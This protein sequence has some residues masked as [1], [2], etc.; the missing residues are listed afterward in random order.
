M[1]VLH[2]GLRRSAR[3]WSNKIA[4]IDGDRRLTYAQLN[5]RVNRLA[6]ALIDLGLEPGDRVGV[7]ML[8]SFRYLEL[9][10]AVNV[11]GGVIVPLN[12]RLA[13]PELVFMLNDCSARLLVVGSEHAGATR[14]I[15]MGVPSLTELILA[16]DWGAPEPFIPYEDFLRSAAPTA[17]EVSVSDTDPA[18]IFY[19]GGTTGVPKGVILTDR[20]LAA[21]AYHVII[22]FG[23]TNQTTYLHT[24]PMFHLADAGSIFAVTAV[25]GAH[26]HSRTFDPQRVLETIERNQVTVAMF[27]PT[28]VTVLVNHPT[29]SNFD[30]SR[31]HRVVYGGSPIAESTLR[32][33]MEVLKCEFIQGYGM[34]EASPLISVLSADDHRLDGSEIV[35]QRLRSAGQPGIGI[36]VRI[37]NENDQE[38]PPETVGEIILRG[39]NVMLG[40]WNRPEETAQVLRGGWLHTGDLGYM[41]DEDYVFIVDRKKDM[42]VSGGEKVGEVAQATDSF[43]V[44]SK[45]FFFPTDRY[46]P[47]SAISN[48]DDA[49][50]FLSLTKD[51]IDARGWEDPDAV[52]NLDNND[53]GTRAT[54]VDSGVPAGRRTIAGSDYT[55]DPAVDDNDTYTRARTTD[56]DDDRDVQLH[57]ER[58][59]AERT[60]GE[61]GAV[62]VGKKVES[63]RETVDVPVDREEVD[64]EYEKYDSPRAASGEITS[65]D[66]EIRV[67]VSEEDAVARK[68]TVATGEVNVDKHRVRETKRVSGQ[69]REERPVIEREGDVDVN[70]EGADVDDARA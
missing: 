43:F 13:V 35:A 68:E 39:D 25:G 16:D 37:V 40:Y 28:M 51:E 56:D 17:P 24:A 20:N 53:V 48:V 45:G 36:D 58:L 9:Y 8:N 46:I 49:K 34:T 3:L 64:V 47:F 1:S 4:A 55:T 62:R 66:E 15:R 67:P 22:H 12:Y 32:R 38:V 31:L 14:E 70:V 7:L 60:T 2:Q 65:D 57:E 54:N 11:A 61:T 69:V 21:N 6:N 23:Y 42:I 52:R 33:A 41:D 5:D 18:A 50:V 44:V 27:V 63:H 10:Y 59:T 19:T 29:V 26:A 30:L